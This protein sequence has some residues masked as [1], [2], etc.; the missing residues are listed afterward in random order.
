MATKPDLP[1]HRVFNSLHG[2]WNLERDMG[3]MGHFMGTARFF[4]A[5]DSAKNSLRYRE[6]GVLHRFDGQK[7]EGYR[8]YD[9]VL[10]DDAIEL[11]FRDPV[12]FGN[13]YVLLSF[14]PAN[15]SNSNN[16]ENSLFAQDHHPCGNDMYHHRMIWQDTNH[17]ETR[18][19]VT[20]PNKDYELH[21]LYQRQTTQN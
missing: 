5:T 14:S 7:F 17:F 21:S 11:L 15:I 19:K 1:V 8:E 4:I 13:R 9:F 20:G 3:D 10:H 6:E 12:G 2:D 16:P 18:I